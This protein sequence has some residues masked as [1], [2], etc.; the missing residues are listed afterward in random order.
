MLRAKIYINQDE[1]ED[2]QIVNS[3]IQNKKGEIK[4]K[5]TTLIDTFTVYHNRADGWIKLLTKALKKI[6]SRTF[7]IPVDVR[8]AER[9]ANLIKELIKNHKD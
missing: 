9:D 8:Q 5:V 3:G 4:Y 2:I 7:E 6:Q 1:L